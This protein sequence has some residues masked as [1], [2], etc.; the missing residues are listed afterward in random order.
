M[1]AAFSKKFFLFPMSGFFGAHFP[2]L[3]HCITPK[4]A[5]QGSAPGGLNRVPYAWARRA[6]C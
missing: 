1:V 5:S 3:L 4:A 2:L 6:I